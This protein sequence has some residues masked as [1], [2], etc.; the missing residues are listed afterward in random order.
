MLACARNGPSR[1]CHLAQRVA[2]DAP[3]RRTWTSTL[4]MVSRAF[5]GLGVR[6]A[7]EDVDHA[8]GHGEVAGGQHHDHAVVLLLVD[9]HLREGRD[10]VHARVG[11]RVGG[12]DHP[13]VEA[14]GDAIGHGAILLHHR[15]GEEARLDVAG[16]LLRRVEEF[17]EVLVQA[18]RRRC[19]RSARTAGPPG[20]GPRW[21]S[22][23]PDCA[24]FTRSSVSNTWLAGRSAGSAGCRRAGS[25]ARRA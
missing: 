5:L 12:E 9:A 23:S 6:L 25:A 3:R 15:R 2:H 8:L 17:G 13:G 10:V 19:R 18:R 1:R 22:V 21:R 16:E 24:F 7:V 20:S 4:Q 11:A 14:D